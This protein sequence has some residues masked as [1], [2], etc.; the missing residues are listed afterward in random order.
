MSPPPPSNPAAG[1]AAPLP[2]AGLF[3]LAGAIFVSVTSE[4][5]PT[6]LLPDMARGLSVSETQVGLL[7]SIFAGVVVLSAAPLTALTRRF[8]RKRLVIVVLLVFAFGNFLSAVAPDY[9]VVVVSRAIG[10]LAHGLFWAVVGAYAAHLVPKHQISRAVAITGSG[11]TAAFVLGVPVG[12]LLGHALGWRLAFAAIGLV[13]LLL[14]GMVIRYLPAVDHRAPVRT[15]EVPLPL[16]RDP[17]VLGVVLIC[18]I[19]TVVMAGQNLFFT[20]IVP[21]FIGVNGFEPDLVGGLLFVYGAGGAVG[22]LLVGW[23]GSRYPR[24]GLVAFFAGVALAVLLL[25]AF[26]RI[27]WLAVG[28][29]VLWGIAFGGSP[30]MLQSRLLQTASQ[31]MRDVGSAYFTTSFNVAIGGGALIGGLLLDAY[32]VGVLPFVDVGV[33]L[34]GIALILLSEAILARRAAA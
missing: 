29:V 9:P 24:S 8:E 12:T 11:A 30:A 5:L 3:I 2:W 31:R 14:V 21:Y 33:T 28:A 20:Y 18:L 19:T 17:S 32:G 22:L 25:G 1:A 26:P 6:G 27:A 34:G 4:V 15:G 13:V 10:G 23:V 7:V 16:R